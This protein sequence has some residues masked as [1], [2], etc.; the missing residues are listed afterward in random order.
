M[1]RI[2]LSAL[3]G[4]FFTGVYFFTAVFAGLIA[5]YGVADI[6]GGVW[7]PA[8]SQFLLGTDSI[9]RDLLS[10]RRDRIRSRQCLGLRHGHR[11]G[12][13]QH[14]R[15]LGPQ[16]HRCHSAQAW[17]APDTSRRLGPR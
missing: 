16:R 8:S 17:Q 14:H 6:V 13:R 5:P 4:L 1:T 12:Q 9:G 2:P 11:L 3:I 15:I 10:H 7:E